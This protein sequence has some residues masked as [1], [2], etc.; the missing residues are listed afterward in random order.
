MSDQATETTQ[1]APAET[2]ATT[3]QTTTPSSDSAPAQTTAPAATPAANAAFYEAFKDEGLKTDPSIQKYQSTEDLARGYVNAVKRLGADPNSL[4]A[5]P[6]GPDDQEGYVAVFKALGA[7][8]KVEDYQI[9]MEGAA[10]ED[11]AAAK[12]FAGEMFAKGPFP[13]SFVAAATEW[14]TGKVAAQNA[15]LLAEA[16]AARV[17]GE[18]ALKAEWGQAYEHRKAE[19]GKLLNDLGGPDLAKEL[20]GSTFGDNPKLASFLGKILDKMAEPGPR[21]EGNPN[22]PGGNPLTPAQ[23]QARARELQS[24]PAFLNASHPQH[25]DVVKARND[26]LRAASGFS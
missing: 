15:E 6:K 11:I 1:A 10:P 4:I 2:P 24:H 22:T 8:E 5:L 20:D 21:N 16:E 12:E 26:A 19:I 25:K 23:H 14:F 3:G 18:Q 9:K 13:A 7:P 17:A